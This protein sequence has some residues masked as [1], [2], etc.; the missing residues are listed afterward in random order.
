MGNRSSTALSDWIGTAFATRNAS[1]MFEMSHLHPHRVF[2]RREALA[3]GF[4]D[5]DLE[6]SLRAGEIA[7]VRHGAYTAYDVWNAADEFERHRLRSHAVLATHDDSTVLSHTSAAIMHGL[8]TWDGDLARV[9]LTRLDRRTDRVCHDV[10]YHRGELPEGHVVR[11]GHDRLITTAPRACIDHASIS[12]VESGLVTLDAFLNANGGRGLEQLR[13]VHAIRHRWPGARR[14][15]ITLRLMR[16]GAESVGETRLRF[17]CWERGLP[18]PE[19][20]VRV[21]DPSGALVGVT[22]FGWNNRS[23]LGEFDGRVKYE[24]LRRSG[25]SPSDAL[26]REKKREDR[27]RE[28]TGSPVIRFVWADL[29]HRDATAARIRHALK[30]R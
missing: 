4:D 11:L 18:E 17:L 9:H 15:Q 19:L 25:E 21:L 6:R 14:L 28:L 7:R 12:S 23:L 27:I 22:D 1:R 30:I 3:A 26:F 20:Q 13:S 5:R 8:P 29:Y 24:Q 10:R 16:A 2:L